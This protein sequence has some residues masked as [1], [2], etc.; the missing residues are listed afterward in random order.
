MTS[1]SKILTVSYG[2]FSCTLEG[3]DDPYNAMKVIAEYF[4]DL[5]ADDRHFGAEPPPPE[6]ALLHQIAER[7]AARLVE[8]HDAHADTHGVAPKRASKSRSRGAASAPVE[9]VEAPPAGPTLRDVIPSGVIAKLARIRQAVL[10]VAAAA[11]APAAPEGGTAD[12]AIDMPVDG[13][14]VAEAPVQA[15]DAGEP[16]VLNRLGSL[17]QNPDF[18]D[19]ARKPDIADDY[20]AE[21]DLDDAEFAAHIPAPVAADTVPDDVVEDEVDRQDL[22]YSPDEAEASEVEATAGIEAPLLEEEPAP[23]PRIDRFALLSA[24]PAGRSSRVN[25]RIIRLHPDAD[26]GS[27]PESRVPAE[28]VVSPDAEIARRMREAGPVEA[29]AEWQAEELGDEMADE[30][31]DGP[32][33]DGLYA[34]HDE[35]ELAEEDLGA[36]VAELDEPEPEAPAF[37]APAFNEPTPRNEPTEGSQ[38]QRRPIVAIRSHEPAGRAEAPSS[39]PLVL[40]SEQLIDRRA[41]AASLPVHGAPVPAPV[42]ADI[43]QTP[44]VQKQRTIVPQIEIDGLTPGTVR[45]GRLSGVIGAGAAASFRD[46]T[47][48]PQDPRVAAQAG[49]FEDEDD[50]DDDLSAEDEAGLLSFVERV[51]VKSMADMLEAAAAYAVCIE[52]R[53]QFTRSQ[54]MRR[55]AACADGRVIDREEGLRSF[56]S[57]LRTGRVQKLNRGNYTLSASSPYLAAARRFA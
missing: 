35:P 7:D 12:P 2:T 22:H 56:G 4:R 55:L 1:E 30:M 40:V 49:D 29:D 46:G 13:V 33:D 53:S 50:L 6:T 37:E 31:A 32:V 5:A 26:E 10:P 52:G 20:E 43:S 11:N 48:A 16:D 54:L 39:P 47:K 21:A 15:Y 51:G 27:M 8:D 18:A 25:S 3:F 23:P 19:Y 17:I 45:T 14:D 34:D 9:P 36:Q 38:R 24:K 41:P 28:P 57:L 42:Q 44:A